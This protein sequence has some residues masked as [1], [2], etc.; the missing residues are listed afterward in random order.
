[1]HR[2]PGELQVLAPPSASDAPCSCGSGLALR[3]CCD[4]DRPGQRPE[5]SE[6]S[7]ETLK[8][9]Y[10]SRR[11]K[12]GDAAALCIR[13]LTDAPTLLPALHLLFLIRRD[14]GNR[15]AALALARR[16]A[17]LAPLDPPMA[18]EFGRLL[19]AERRWVEAERQA[20]HAVRLAPQ[21]ADA[22]VLLAK[23]FGERKDFTA[24][25]FQL[26]RAL[27]FAG[28]QRLH[29]LQELAQIQVQQGNLPMARV[30]LDEALT[31]APRDP[32]L[33][34]QLAQ[35]EEYG[36]NAGKA[37]SLLAEAGL[38]AGRAAPLMREARA[39]LAYDAGDYAAALE[40][41]EDAPRLDVSAVLLKGRALD[42]LGRYEEAFATFEAAQKIDYDDAEARAH[43]AWIE[44]TANHYK[45]FFVKS[46][47][48]SLPRAEMAEG[49]KQPIFI[50]GFARS[51]TTLVE[52]SL[53][54][55]SRIAAGGEISSLRNVVKH[56]QR[57]LQSALPYPN[58][59]T[60]LWM[61]DQRLGMNMLRD[62]Y[63]NDADQLHGIAGAQTP[64]FTDKM[65]FN[66]MHLALISL[67]LPSAPVIHMIRHPLDVVLS[68][69]SHQLSG[70]VRSRGDLVSVA[71]HYAATMDL[72]E[73]YRCQEST[74]R[75]LAVR[76]E[77]V[78]A[79]QRGQIARMLDF[80][81]VP[82]EEACLDFESNSRYARTL[83]FSQVRRPL[84]EDGVFRYR[85]YRRQLAPAYPVLEPIIERLGYSLA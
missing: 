36:R 44:N 21:S 66:E 65:I 42:R 72:V 80:V 49:R 55:H 59:L 46:L 61:G 63:L 15:T 69:F 77:D 85:N 40:A 6:P 19:F 48:Q 82:F 23:V 64:W 7:A 16:L 32:G 56:A 17:R 50:A 31:L 84:N 43:L 3:V 79:S 22:N 75:Y 83:S 41:L 2:E 52:Q 51:G 14:E 54:M 45:K 29:L 68:V 38:E 34:S 53:S 12:I 33:L 8:D 28:E 76:Y 60:E 35:V 30:T 47:M 71:R 67:I 24:A 18:W 62:L 74:G 20:R 70:G 26:R 27:E 58:A 13:L 73:H 78:V 39:R 9:I 5:P 1:M 10:A 81:G 11:G 57:L 25:E 37:A 4:L